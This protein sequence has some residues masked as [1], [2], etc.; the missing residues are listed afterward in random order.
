VS[1]WPRLVRQAFTHM[2]P[3]G[4]L[5][6]QEFEVTLRSDDDTMKLAPTLCEYLDKL[7]EASR[8][9]K[10]EMNIAEKHKQTMIDAGFETVTEQ[11]FK[12]R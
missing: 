12:V 9:F 11:I 5:E 10:K 6:L 1:N 8:M 7:H 4:W 2:R 3:G